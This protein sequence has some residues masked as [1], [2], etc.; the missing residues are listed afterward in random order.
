MSLRR[1][2]ISLFLF[3]VLAV[4]PAGAHE[5]HINPPSIGRSTHPY[6]Q[7]CIAPYLRIQSALADG[8]L[9]KEIKQAA[10]E[11]S[12]QAQAAAGQESEATGRSML[13]VMAAGAQ[14]IA[15]AG[16]PEA[17][18]QGFGQL[19]QVMLPFF[20][21][22]TGHLAEHDL[23]LFYCADKEALQRRDKI[24]FST[25]WMQKGK[26]PKSPYG[27]ACPD[28]QVTRGEDLS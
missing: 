17:A 10:G 8:R 7:A 14:A 4:S 12:K 9:D 16:N 27:A 22:W 18:R 24:D 13:E 20:I 19:N 28:L 21:I 5:G 1:F 11:L 6:L 26:T 25:G 15:S 2:I 3:S 23:G